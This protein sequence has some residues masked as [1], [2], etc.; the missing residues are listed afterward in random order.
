MTGKPGDRKSC[1]HLLGY[2]TVNRKEEDKSINNNNNTD[3]T[4]LIFVCLFIC[5][6]S[7]HIHIQKSR[8]VI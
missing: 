1:R 2:M 6:R 3:S 4:K 5:F 8:T 7:K